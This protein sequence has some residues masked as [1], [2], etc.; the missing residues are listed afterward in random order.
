MKRFTIDD[1]RLTIADWSAK[2]EPWSSIV[3][4]HSGLP[5]VNGLTSVLARA[6]FIPAVQSSIVNKS[7][8][9]NRK[10]SIE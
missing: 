4:G 7:S 3:D 5:V 2:H 1:L 9:V 6:S 8:I 10:S